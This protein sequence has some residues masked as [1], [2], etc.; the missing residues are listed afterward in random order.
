MKTI[1]IGGVPVG[2][3]HPCYVIAEAGCNHNRSLDLAKQLVDMSADARSDA[4]KF[5]TF[6][7]DTIVS[8][9]A[10][11][12]EHIG[13]GGGKTI[14]D[15]FRE[16]ELPTEFHKPIAEHC[17]ERDISFMSSVFYEEGV[18]L[19][20]E[21]NV[22]AYKIA[23]FEIGHLP[24]L[25]EVARTGKPIVLSTGMATLCDIERALDT[26]SAAGNDK[27]VLLHCVSNYP[28]KAEDY[29][30]R[31]VQ[32][33]KAAFDLPVGVSDHTPGIEMPKI[34][35]AVGADMI[36]KH[37][38]TDQTLPGPDHSFSVNPAEL[39]AMMEAIRSVEAML[40]S[41]RKRPLESER[42]MAALGRRSLVAKQDIPAGGV[43][44]AE[45][46]AV[47]RPGSGI[48]PYLAD[49]IVGRKVRRAIAADEPF[50][51][52]MFLE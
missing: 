26:L 4:V 45:M 1:E 23:S 24:L 10:A 39:T 27:V 11:A 14:T 16:L 12:M 20:E 22:P 43:V 40:G 44:T 52:D 51:W 17:K 25:R 13:G 33:L 2:D 29:N 34:S 50:V 15:L 48:E 28:A 49:V 38:T 3:G 41:P 31:V 35:V 9:K 32:S 37:V 19:L 36:E 42:E 8:S 21:L 30:L 47:K 6:T 5:Q 46:I 18:A 7:A